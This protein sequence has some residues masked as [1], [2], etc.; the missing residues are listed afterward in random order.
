MMR[1]FC[2]IPSKFRFTGSRCLWELHHDSTQPILLLPQEL[3]LAD[4]NTI[5][6]DLNKLPTSPPTSEEPHFRGL[7]N[8]DARL[9]M[10]L[11]VTINNL[12][13]WIPVII[14]TGAGENLYISKS[15]LEK[16]FKLNFSGHNVIDA[17]VKTRAQV[18]EL[19]SVTG[20]ARPSSPP[21]RPQRTQTSESAMLW[22]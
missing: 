17:R 4:W 3:M 2:P 21:K 7:A 13:A 12:S 9:T 15:H 20:R 14:D 8:R 19:Q 1:R 16:E 5:V 11:Y 18:F 6:V 10:N 22:V